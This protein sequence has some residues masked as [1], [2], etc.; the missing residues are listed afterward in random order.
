MGLE[1]RPNVSVLPRMRYSG[2]CSMPL[3]SSLR[4][5]CPSSRCNGSKAVVQANGM[6]GRICPS[7]SA[8]FSMLIAP[9]LSDFLFRKGVKEWRNPVMAYLT[10]ATARR[11]GGDP[12][13][14][15]TVGIVSGRSII[16]LFLSFSGIIGSEFL[17]HLDEGAIWVRG[18]LAPST[19]PTEGIRLMNQ[20]RAVLC[21]FPEVPQCT[22]QTGRP[23]D[24]TDT[25]GFFNTEYFVDLKPKE[26]W[27]PTLYQDKDEL[28]SAMNRELDKIPGVLWGFSQPIEDNMEEAVSG[29]RRTGR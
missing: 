7:G 12:T 29:V 3:A 11:A 14:L 18:T 23:D 28:I 25:T 16:A 1:P 2:R 10:T 24:G 8:Y 22:S 4:P 6:D 19:G 21:S 13:P 26:Q 15:A 20:A 9:V 5:I 27:R 17:P